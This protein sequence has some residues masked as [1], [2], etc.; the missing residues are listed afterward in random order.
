[1]GWWWLEKNI[2]IDGK[3]C[4]GRRKINK[5]QDWIGLKLKRTGD[6]DVFLKID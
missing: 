1:M 5:N 2:K 3:F 4:V 6:E